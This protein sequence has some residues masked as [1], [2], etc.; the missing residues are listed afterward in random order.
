MAFPTSGLSNNQVHKEGNRAFVYDSTLGVW[1]QVRETNRIQNNKALQGELGDGISI[2]SDVTGFAGIKNVDMWRLTASFNGGQDIVSNWERVDTDAFVKL[3]V[4]GMTQ[5]AGIFCFPVTGYWRVDFGMRGYLNGDSRYCEC[6]IKT[7]EDDQSNWSDAS[8]GS[9]FV[10][11]TN[12]SHTTFGA[13]ATHMVKVT[14]VALI[15]V[16]FHVGAY[17]SSTTFNG[18]TNA[19]LTYVVFTRLGDI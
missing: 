13:Y 10:Q 6:Y 1:D 17:T 19:N 9:T 18:D 7:T 2:S 12:G 16:K 5:Q 14:D 15:K 4:G 11:Q 3:G 8:Y